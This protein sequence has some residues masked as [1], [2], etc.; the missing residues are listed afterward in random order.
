MK[1]DLILDILER[2][3]DHAVYPEFERNDYEN[4]NKQT[5]KI[6]TFSFDY[7]DRILLYLY[8]KTDMKKLTHFSLCSGIGGLDLA[9]DQVIGFL[10]LFER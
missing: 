3:T 10:G 1:I 6:V 5:I 4:K 9:N 2:K 7:N 8:G